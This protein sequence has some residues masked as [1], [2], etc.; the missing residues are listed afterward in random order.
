MGQLR[1][2]YVDYIL[3][4]NASNMLRPHHFRASLLQQAGLL[5]A[6]IRVFL[7]YISAR[8]L[9]Y[10]NL[11]RMIIC[12]TNRCWQQMKV[13]KGTGN[14]ISSILTTSSIWLTQKYHFVSS[15]HFYLCLETSLHLPLFFNLIHSSQIVPF[16]S[17]FRARSI[18]G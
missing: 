7:F 8:N 12:T 14:I 4:H 9:I 3:Q 5:G 2:S 17:L 1:K 13:F 6:Y 16:S 15:Y 11:Q 10:G 18:L